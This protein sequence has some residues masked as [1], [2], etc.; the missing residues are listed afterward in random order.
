MSQITKKSGNIW[1][2][3]LLPEHNGEL[4]SYLIPKKAEFSYSSRKNNQNEMSFLYIFNQT[5][6]DKKTK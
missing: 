3:V 1:W 2:P 5:N 6:K 4:L